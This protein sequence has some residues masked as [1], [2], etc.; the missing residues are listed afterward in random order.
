MFYYLIINFFIYVLILKLSYK[1]FKMEMY[2]PFRKAEIYAFVIINFISSILILYLFNFYIVLIFVLLNSLFFYIIYH[3]LNM[4][5]T[6][7]RTKILLDL[8]DSKK[9]NIN[10]YTSNNYSTKKILDNRLLRFQSS[11]QIYIDLSKIYLYENKSKF[12][13]TIFSIFKLVKF[14]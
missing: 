5:Q 2:Y 3:T 8:Y 4:I 6:S 7:P 13:K 11:N 10:E 9:I 1:M 14:F 12:I